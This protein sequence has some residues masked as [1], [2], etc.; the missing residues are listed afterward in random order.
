[1]NNWI[2]AE[3][4]LV[5]DARP[6]ELYA[7][8]SDYRVGHPAILPKEYFTKGLT[9]EQGGSGAGTILHSSVS[10][11]GREFPFRQMVTEPEPGRV[12]VETDLDTGQYSTFTFDALNGGKQTRVTISSEF[13]LSKGLMG[14]MERLTKA[15]MARKM[16]ARELQNLAA[17][18]RTVTP[19]TN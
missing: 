17:Y 5:I 4:A 6:E 1:M 11:M 13:P 8:V 14:V 12:I 19:V 16:F 15:S 18:V 9:V 10:V 3:A 2:H 7:V